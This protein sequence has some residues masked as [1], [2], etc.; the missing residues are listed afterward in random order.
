[1]KDRATFEAAVFGGTKA[2][3]SEYGWDLSGLCRFCGKPVEHSDFALAFSYWK[4]NGVGPLW[5]SSHK[6]C[7]SEGAKREAYECQ[8]LDAACNDCR[9]FQRSSGPRGL[10][11]LDATERITFPCHAEA[12]PCFVH[13]KDHP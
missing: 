7:L 11:A 9:H 10:C 5:A 4:I 2:E 6:A 3:A 8:C 1:M 13:R 12:N